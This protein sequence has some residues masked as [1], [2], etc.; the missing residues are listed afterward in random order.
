MRTAMV[1]LAALCVLVALTAP[2]WPM[3]LRPAAASIA[4]DF[5]S[6][7]KDLPDAALRGA[8]LP[9][10]CL[11]A[12]SWVLLGVAGGLAWARKRL[13]ADR[14]VQKAPTWDCGYAAPSSRMQYTAS[15]FASPL[16]TLFRIL[17]RPREELRSPQGLFPTRASFKSHTA[18]VFHDYLYRPMFLGIV[19]AASKLRWLQQGRIQ[20]YV[21]YIA[22]TILVLLVW[23]LG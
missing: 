2:L 9:L 5:L 14:S 6:S 15:S 1:V 10:T 22:L 21:L 18:D 13:L 3:V 19:W 12:A 7:L 23:K 17:L 20:L 16:V 4:P 8:T 11:C